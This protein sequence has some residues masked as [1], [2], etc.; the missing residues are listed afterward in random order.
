MKTWINFVIAKRVWVIV[1]VLLF[2][3]G[4]LSQFSRF[5]VVLSS[6]NMMPQSNHY[7]ITGNEL[8][9]T[10]GNKNTVVV[11]LTAMHG[12]IYQTAILEKVKR[13]TERLMSTPG[14]I[15]TNV[16]SLAA[17]KAKGI[18]GNESGMI[19]RPMME[20]VPPTSA[21]I[22]ALQKAVA[23]I[24]A[25]EGLLVSKDQKT[26]A[27]VAEF[28]ENPTGFK[29]IEQ[30]VRA[31]VDSERDDNVQITLGGLP[32]FLSLIEK[33]SER[34]GFLL[35]LA[36]VV[37]GLIHYEAFR[38]F[39]AAALPLVTAIL[40]VIW[41]LAFLVITRRPMEAFNASTSILILA[42]AAG[43]GVQILKRYYEEFAKLKTGR[44]RGVLKELSRQ[45]V[46]NAMVKVG[47]VMLV[48]G[49]VASLGFFS[50]TVFEIKAIRTFGIMTGVGILSALVLELT[51]IPAIRSILPAP[52]EKE[53]TRERTRTL[54]DRAIE[55]IFFWVSEKRR[56]VYLVAFG[57]IVALSLGGYWLKVENSQ[58]QYFFGN[59]EARLDDDRLNTRLAGA[60][61]LYVLV[62]GQ[63]DDAIKDPAVL[64]AMDRVQQHLAQDPRVGKTL[65]LVDF[66]KRMNQAMNADKAEFYRVPENRDLVAQYLLLYSNSGEPQDFDAYVDNG[67]RKADIQMF[68]K[69]DDSVAL[70]EVVKD[71]QAFA[72]R[73]FPAGVHIQ[74]GGGIASSL[75]LNEEMIRCKVLNILQILGCVFLMSA[76]IFRSVQA[77][78]LILVPLVAAVFV[79]FGVMG[80]VGIPLNIPTALVSAMAVGIGADYAIYLTFRMREELRSG[81][82]E[83]SGLRTAF[84]SAGKAAI[85][86]STAVAGGFGVLVFSW[87]FNMHV[88]MGF[89]IGLA[90]LVSS[91]STLTVFASL[92]LSLR[93]K[94][95]FPSASESVAS[96]PEPEVLPS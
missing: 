14:V 38:T 89:L 10:F 60:S 95:I 71:T 47:P 40:S 52:S 45:A 28:R 61:T 83:A 49:I 32:I 9:R 35:P 34:M 59:L 24:P 51:F 70:T 79:N 91:F 41:S 93:P 53:F 75:A 15:K 16:N 13:I 54:W 20:R 18:E 94:F 74:I 22:E 11:G 76:V 30:Q 86:V 85:F 26:T 64:N 88:W 27:I 67:Y 87:G 63:V 8:E 46:L 82:P 4:L 17:R 50:L 43:H 80:L 56:T 29:T 77:G 36:I 66:L 12:T 44:P 6:D 73:V 19:V 48:A 33:F 96:L 57:A 25:Y 55:R 69:T 58:R 65:S 21:E 62:D 92:I 72:E 23:S 39:Q 68:L 2:T 84:L 7:V 3:T 31:A 1:A 37:I 42:I 78:L 5:Q 90:M 81:V